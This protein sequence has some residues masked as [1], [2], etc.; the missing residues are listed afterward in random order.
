MLSVIVDASTHE[1]PSRGLG[2][3]HFGMDL[4]CMAHGG[5]HQ[6]FVSLGV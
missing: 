3:V 1:F 5:L 6:L 2:E 4:L